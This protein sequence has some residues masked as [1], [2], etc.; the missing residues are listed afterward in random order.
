[1]GLGIDLEPKN[2]G[3][4]LPIVKLD[5]RAGR[6]F[7]VDRADGVSTPTDITKHFKCVMDLENVEVGWLDFATGAAPVM[8]LNRLGE[9]FPVNPGGNAKEGVRILMK[10]SKECGG[11]VRELASNAKSALRGIN[12]LHDLYKAEASS[13][14]GMLPVVTLR[15]MIPVTTGGGQQK[16]TNYEP[17]FEI[18]DW[19]PRPQTLVYQPRQTSPNSAAATN[20]ATHRPTPPV[21][22]GQRVEAP[23]SE[24]QNLSEDFG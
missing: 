10:L 16:S 2:S 13:K 14:P 11:D 24:A 7:R 21:T 19:V 1:M 3:D 22:G 4:F 15:D 23:S 20:G 12:K 6:I 5:S 17:V 18:V 9:K 8:V